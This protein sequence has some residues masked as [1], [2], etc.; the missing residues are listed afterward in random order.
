MFKEESIIVKS[1]VELIKKGTF[2]RDQIPA[3]GNLR[4]V[5]F[6]ILDKEENDV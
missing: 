5:V 6:S 3:L 1:W 4:E 2:T